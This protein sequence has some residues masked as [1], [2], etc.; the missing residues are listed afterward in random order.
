MRYYAAMLH[1]LDVEKN[2]KVLPYHIEYLDKLDQQGKV[3]GRGPFSDGS[4]GMIIYIA[5][6]LEE[7]QYMAENDPHVLE[8]VRRLE[9]KEW[10]IWKIS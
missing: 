6:T 1:M 2:K 3:F 4:G 7:A 9:L 5:D 10:E 8:G